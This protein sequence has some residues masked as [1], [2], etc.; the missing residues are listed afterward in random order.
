MG[1]KTGRWFIAAVG[2]VLLLLITIPYLYAA[3]RTDENYVF[4]GLLQNP[5]D[6]N[7][8]LAKMFQGWQGAWRFH[9]PYTAEPGEGAYLFLY[10]LFLGHV[11]RWTGLSLILVYHLA[12]L[13]GTL[14]LLGMLCRFFNST[15]KGGQTRR[16]AIVWATF[17]AGLG[18]MVVPWGKFTADFWVA[19]TFPFLSAYTNPHF[20]L[21]LALLLYLLLPEKHKTCSKG[22]A[23]LAL[24]VIL[25]FGVLL[26]FLVEA[27]TLLRVGWRTPGGRAVLERTLAILFG[28]CV[29]L[30]YA[31]W[32][33]SVDPVLADWNAQNLTPTPPW[34]DVGLSLSPAL[35]LA[36]VGGYA[37]WK[38][39]QG[40]SQVL[41]LWA[42]VGLGLL[43]VPIGLQ[44]RLM[45]GLYVP[46]V[47]L[48]A[49]GV[50]SLSAGSEPRFRRLAV[51]VCLLS[52]LTNVVVMSA[53][54]YGA[55]RR[56]AQ[57]YLSRGEMQALSW[58]GEHTSPEA[59]VLASPST[60][61]FVPAYSGRR[62]VYGH[63]FETVNADAE[64]AAV[65]SFFEGGWDEEEDRDFLLSRG[66]DYI[67][68]G[69]REAELG[70]LPLDRGVT[71]L[72]SAQGV[73]IYAVEQDDPSRPTD[74]E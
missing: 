40:A 38:D 74:D 6:G 44:R 25:P 33:T 22:L 21:G 45:L 23:A 60:G 9:L 54:F 59:L 41:I 43:F 71:A 30:G 29:P 63:P 68:I 51:G 49:V 24:G 18:W 20:P 12:R 69:P 8:Y 56:E 14:A 65:R 7:T 57:V 27:L 70:G 36:L 11:S 53:G 1:S 10:Y 55:K 50:E 35:F 16:L 39:R 67:F 62:V 48:G 17:G 46:L 72:Y 64:E 47:G 26:A 32:V 5:V 15:I 42:I 3:T 28:G 4:G 58:L 31:V 52:F 34:W 37:S 2:V 61:L 66:V 13:L 19:E 73:T